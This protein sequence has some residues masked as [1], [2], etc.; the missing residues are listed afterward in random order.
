[1]ARGL[2]IFLTMNM[3]RLVLEIF[4]FAVAKLT[5]THTLITLWL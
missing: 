4:I 3:G 5:G 1:M 2:V